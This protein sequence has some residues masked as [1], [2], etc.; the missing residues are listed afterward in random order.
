MI[1]TTLFPGRY[2]QGTDS[3]QRLGEELSRFGQKGFAICTP[4]VFEKTWCV[5]QNE[6]QK[7]IQYNVEKFS[8]GPIHVTQEMVFSAL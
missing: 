5:L 6:I 4:F 1:S 2:V 8:N 7:I 3:I